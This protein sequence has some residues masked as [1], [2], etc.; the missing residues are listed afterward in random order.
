MV[1]VMVNTSSQLFQGYPSIACEYLAMILPGAAMF[2]PIVA[3]TSG[4]HGAQAKG[5][6]A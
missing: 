4:A 2:L 5:R 6:Q 1:G 3:A